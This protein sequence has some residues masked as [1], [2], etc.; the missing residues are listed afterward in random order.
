MYVCKR[1]CEKIDTYGYKLCIPLW[2]AEKWGVTPVE[3]GPN[4]RFCSLPFFHSTC[5]SSTLEGH[6]PAGQFKMYNH[7][8]QKG[9]LSLLVQYITLCV[10]V[11][12]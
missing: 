4:L 5:L 12:S 8:L 6:S 9:R 7:A 11:I 3:Q 1:E 2:L 10:F